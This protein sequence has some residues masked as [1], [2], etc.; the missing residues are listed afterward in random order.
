MRNRKKILLTLD[1]RC[2]QHTKYLQTIFLNIYTLKKCTKKSSFEV[3]KLEYDAL[4]ANVALL[5]IK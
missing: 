2:L 4:N 1:Q 3:G 5:D